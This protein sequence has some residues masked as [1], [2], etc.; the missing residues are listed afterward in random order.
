MLYSRYVM[1]IAGNSM[2]ETCSTHLQYVMI[3]LSNAYSN[4]VDIVNNTHN[5]A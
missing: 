5:I 3:V 1:N 4:D 2:S